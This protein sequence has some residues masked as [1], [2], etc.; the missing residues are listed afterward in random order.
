MA[1]GTVKWFNDQKGYGFISAEG[2]QDDVYVHFSAIEGR[3][4][5]TL[6]EG[7]LVEFEVSSTERGQHQASHVIRI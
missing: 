3:G 1:R 6:H 2:A 4:F 5:R 7:E